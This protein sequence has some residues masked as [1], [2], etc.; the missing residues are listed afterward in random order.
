MKAAHSHTR[1]SRSQTV[2]LNG[3]KKNLRTVQTIFL[4]QTAYHYGAMDELIKYFKNKG[5]YMT[6][7]A[8]RRRAGLRN[9]SNGSENVNDVTV[10]RRQKDDNQAWR[11]TGSSSSANTSNGEDDLWFSKGEL[12]FLMECK[13]QK[14]S[15]K[16]TSKNKQDN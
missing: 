3:A 12:T 9:S 15:S 11:E 14:D 2:G 16:Q 5:K 4:Y 13:K 7:Y 10:S 1:V 8:L 6:C